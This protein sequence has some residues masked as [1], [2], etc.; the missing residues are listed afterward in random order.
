MVAPSGNRGRLARVSSWGPMPLALLIAV[1]VGQLF[2]L[3]DI[4]RGGRSTP[5]PSKATV[6]PR[7]PIVVDSYRNLPL[8]FVPNE[9]QTNPRVR[10]AARAGS[11]SFWFT[12][13][14]VVFGFGERQEM[15]LR[16]GFTGANPAP[17]VEGRQS[18]TG[19][20]SYL[21]G[22]DPARWHR[23][24][25]TYH[26]LVYRELWPG[27]DMAVHGA[28]GRLKYEFVVRPGAAVDSIRLH[29]EG[30][31][32]LAMD[33]AGNLLVR[34]ILSTLTDERPTSFQLIGGR[35]VPVESRYRLGKGMSYG[36]AVGAYDRHHPVVIDPGLVYSTYL[37]GQGS[38]SGLGL[39]VDGAGSVY[40][41]GQTTSSDFPTTA[42]AFARS[43]N[44]FPDVFVTKL[45]PTG[46][47]LVYSTYLGGS[48]T[49][50]GAGIVV[51][52]AGSAY[53]SGYTTSSD[54][55]TTPGA[56][57]T[58]YNG[59][60]DVF[61]TKLDPT[62]SALVYSTY[63]GGSSTDRGYGIA[64][65]GAGSAYLTG[66][67]T[68][69]DFPSTTGAFDMSFN[70][71]GD[72][73]VTKLDAAGSG[74][75]Y[76]TYL[77]GSSI[78]QGSNDWG[79]AIAVEGSGSAYVTGQ[80]T[81]SDFPTTAGAFDTSH[82]VGFDVFVTKL[83]ATGSALVYST[84]LGGNSADLG[85]GIA[86]DGDGRAYVTGY[87][88]SSDFPTTAGAFD[89]SPN[90]SLDAFVTKLD[91]TG[92][93]L[94]YST[95]LGGSSNDLGLGIAVDGGGDVYVTGF[96]ASPNFPTTAA[97]LSRSLKGVEDAFVTR[98]DASGSAL[99]YSTFLGG[100]FA[101]S[102]YDIAVDG[103]GSAYVVGSTFSPDF[104]TTAGAF[105]TS[106]NGG[107]DVAVLK[108]QTTS[109][110]PRRTLTLSPAAGT[111]PVATSHTVTALLTE[112]SASPVPDVAVRFSVS[113][114]VTTSG[115]CT[116]DA[117]GQCGFTYSGPQFPGSDVISAFADTNENGTL[118]G[119]EPAST[120]TK[121]WVL[122]VSTTGR[123]TGW[124][125]I[126]NASGE[127]VTFFFT[128]RSDGGLEG[129]CTVIDRAGEKTIKCLDVTALVVNGNEVT[130][131]GNA[132]ENGNA[133]S[134]LIQAADNARRGKGVDTFSIHTAAGYA[135][136][137]TLT[138]GNIRVQE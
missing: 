120:A 136:S 66:Q 1:E 105:D 2:A 122:P 28:E 5:M 107:Y 89:T 15:V 134:Y 85:L 108:L 73:F 38:E 119:D 55:P 91:A 87:T 58:S 43:L 112:A 93:A 96:T 78:D 32:R 49:E 69:S 128:A 131:F 31:Q 75:V 81:S 94:V 62:G 113:G 35:R 117:A 129:S 14:E 72:A 76:S 114:S 125:Q 21:F 30:A 39:A 82:D 9:G 7:K 101:D 37:G 24:L 13:T 20:V 47:A 97:A 98:L 41:T 10:Y 102:G 121:A 130:I 110:P 103:A 46:S 92:S 22:N 127:S 18:G 137:G 54:F 6:A 52:G 133:T 83:D 29:Y 19:R 79:E 116:T 12:P 99:A 77:G 8:V 34:T 40:V 59:S 64:V 135:A 71:G 74:L 26:E 90:G 106:W 56:F 50:L 63:L 88:T 104:P 60:D 126:P 16:L 4:A 17:V 123:A 138:M 25:P 111:N 3:P 45:D 70:G 115:S 11:A 65:D 124:G 84:F 86:F 33:P 118:D 27:I 61:V 68:S 95:R 109:A 80:T 36:F 132:T 100:S 53:V 51:D 67:T 48:S 57:D 23:D 44:G 42:G